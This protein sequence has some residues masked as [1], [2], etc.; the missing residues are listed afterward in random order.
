MIAP[1]SDQSEPTRRYFASLVDDYDRAYRG[2]GR[3]LLQRAVNRFL[4][5]SAFRERLAIVRSVLARHGVTGKQVLDLGCGT[6]EASIAAARIGARATG[7][8]FVD[9]MIQLARRHAAEANLSDRATFRVHDIARAYPDVADVTLLI[10]V[11]EYYGDMSALLGLAAAATRELIIIQDTAASWWRR[12]LRRVVA[13]TKGIHLSYR[14]PE[15]I[16]R[17]MAGLGWTEVDRLTGASFTIFT[18]RP[19]K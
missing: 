9:E 10:G 8:D 15:E 12:T 16:V 4:R 6:G 13:R 3:G 1:L 17:V 2:G 7:L 5:S 11:V 14:P 19:A 18:F